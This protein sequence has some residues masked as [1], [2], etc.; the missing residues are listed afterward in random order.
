MHLWWLSNIESMFFSDVKPWSLWLVHWKV[1][2][3]FVVL[4]L[5]FSC[6][7]YWCESCDWFIAFLYLW[8]KYKIHLVRFIFG[9]VLLVVY[10]ITY[11]DR[12]YYEGMYTCS[13]CMMNIVGLPCDRALLTLMDL[14]FCHQWNIVGLLFIFINLFIHVPMI[15]GIITIKNGS[16]AALLGNRIVNRKVT[17]LL[18][19]QL[20]C[21]KKKVVFSCSVI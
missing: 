18:H 21:C 13:S 11:S 1:Q 17:C 2:I 3:A 14:W 9:K 8:S 16:I 20:V 5:N 10:T 6:T 4:F 19:M 7:V 12:A 15:S